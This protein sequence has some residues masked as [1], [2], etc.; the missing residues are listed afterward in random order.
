MTPKRQPRKR[1]DLERAADELARLAGDPEI[2]PGIHNY[3][4]RWC[5]R[6]PLTRRCLV[7]KVEAQRRARRERPGARAEDANEAFWDDLAESF[8]VALKLIRREAARHGIDLDDP[9]FRAQAAGEER[10]RRR[11]AAQRGRALH[12]LAS[13][14]TKSAGNVLERLQPSLAATEAALQTEARLGVGA[15]AAEAAAIG[16]ALEVVQW[17][18]FF[19]EVKLRRATDGLVDA[20]EE[21]VVAPS[22]NANGSAKIALIAIERS[23]GAWLR[24]RTACN[25][26]ADTILDLLVRLERLRRAVERE[27]PNARAF[28]RPGFDA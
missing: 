23:V 14:Y 15:P 2:V 7:F 28:R 3:C 25:D 8:A 17:Y 13:G 4:D 20:A 10:R 6:C 9:E 1:V 26:E 11:L 19:I 22:D 24:L 27:F 5:E 12:R 18:Q 16:D 21:G